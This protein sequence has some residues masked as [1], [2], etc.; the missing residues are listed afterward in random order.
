MK[1]WVTLLFTSPFLTIIKIGSCVSTRFCLMF[2][3]VHLIIAYV[4]HVCTIFSF[5]FYDI[6][7]Y[8]IEKIYTEF[9]FCVCFQFKDVSRA[10]TILTDE[11]KRN[12]YDNYGSLG[13]YIAEQFGE[14][15]VNAYFLV[16]SVWCKVCPSLFG[17]KF[18]S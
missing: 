6:I 17:C 13:L 2:L 14:E 8:N 1:E 18:M 3:Y 11:T 15:S 5:S 9:L 16:T 10:H 4:D 12:I 7:S